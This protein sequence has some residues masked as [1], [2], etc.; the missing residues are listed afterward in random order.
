MKIYTENG[1]NRRFSLEV[2]KDNGPSQPTLI[3]EKSAEFLP[4]LNS[5]PLISLSLYLSPWELWALKMAIEE[6]I[7]DEDKDNWFGNNY[8]LEEYLKDVQN[9]H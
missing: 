4:E 1:D 7:K 5:P 3:I 2:R 6:A 8:S 9:N